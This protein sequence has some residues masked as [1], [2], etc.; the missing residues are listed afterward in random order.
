MATERSEPAAQQ[1]KKPAESDPSIQQDINFILKSDLSETKA[2]GAAG[3]TG[4][5][6]DV[7]VPAPGELPA[8]ATVPATTP[9][10]SALTAAEKSLQPAK[11]GSADPSKDAGQQALIATIMSNPGLMAILNN[12]SVQNFMSHST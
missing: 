8:S 9:V 11:D 1:P 7:A 4:K 2:E 3:K 5:R 12:Q 6:G 10:S